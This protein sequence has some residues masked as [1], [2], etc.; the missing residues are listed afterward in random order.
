MKNP[1]HSSLI[2]LT[3]WYLRLIFTFIY[4]CLPRC[5]WTSVFGVCLIFPYQVHCEDRPKWKQRFHASYYK[6]L[7]GPLDD[8]RERLR[9]NELSETVFFIIIFYIILLSFFIFVPSTF[10]GTQVRTVRTGSYAPGDN[11]RARSKALALA[12]RFACRSWVTSQ[13]IPQMERDR[14]LKI[15]SKLWCACLEK[16]SHDLEVVMK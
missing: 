16:L 11:V 12:C 5:I 3:S 1:N 6:S 9:V 7:L 14:G 4:F 2:K 8:L 15:S 13:D 10:S